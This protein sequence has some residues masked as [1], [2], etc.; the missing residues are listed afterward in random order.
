MNVRPAPH[1]GREIEDFRKIRKC[2][3]PGFSSLGT[4]RSF[5]H[6]FEGPPGRTNVIATLRLIMNV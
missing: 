2:R 6:C 1:I 3:R 5:R 4:V